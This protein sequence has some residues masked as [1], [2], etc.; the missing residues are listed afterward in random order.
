M[1]NDHKMNKSPKMNILFV[2]SFSLLF[3]CIAMFILAIVF[4]IILEERMTGAIIAISGFAICL[5]AIILAMLSK[6]KT[7]QPA[8]EHNSF[9]EIYTNTNDQISAEKVNTLYTENTEDRFS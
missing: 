4:M 2:I 3:L 5:I 9:E 7:N 6:P 8:P 1:N